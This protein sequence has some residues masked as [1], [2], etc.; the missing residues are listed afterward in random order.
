MA[1]TPPKP[2]ITRELLPAKT[3]LGVLVM[4]AEIGTVET[5]WK[6]EKK[7]PYKVLLSFDFP[8]QRMDY[9]KDGVTKNVPRRKT[10]RV[11]F[12]YHEKSTLGQWL[13]NWIGEAPSNDFDLFSLLGTSAMITISHDAGKDGTVWDNIS[14]VT[15][16]IDGIEPIAAEC[17]LMRYSFIE[18]K[19]D[20]PDNIPDWVVEKIQESPEWEKLARYSGKQEPDPTEPDDL[21]GLEDDDIPF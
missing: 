20:I 10:S 9:E 17:D 21:S 1:S 18:H 19:M 13:K 4:V 5:E 6:G 11:T 3:H 16:L 2:K 7:Y 14:N 12:S 15:Q 8:K